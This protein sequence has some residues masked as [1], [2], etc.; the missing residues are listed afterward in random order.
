MKARLKDIM[1]EGAGIVRNS[2][3]LNSALKKLEDLKSGFH[4]TDKC[5][6]KAEYEFRNMLTVA[7]MV[8]TSAIKRK[9]S[10]GANYRTDYPKVD[11]KCLH[12]T[13]TRSSLEDFKKMYRA[14]I[15]NEKSTGSDSG[16][17][18]VV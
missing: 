16:C 7:E 6:S 5:I 13:I 9:E 1:W 10:R 14:E 17:G 2:D 8:I 18:A 12:T 4:R 3:T 15:F 11:E